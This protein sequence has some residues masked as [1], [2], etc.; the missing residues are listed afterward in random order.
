MLPL[1]SLHRPLN[2]KGH[3]FRIEGFSSLEWP[4]GAS[5]N[6]LQNG[7]HPFLDDM[8]ADFLMV[9]LES[10][11]I[12]FV[13]K[14]AER[15]VTDIMQQPCKSQKFFNIRRGRELAFFDSIKGWIKLLRE[16][17]GDMHGP[18]RVLEASV[19][20]SGKYPSSAL[21][22][23]DTTKSLNP[24]GIDHIPFGFFP[25]YTVGHHDIVINRVGDQ[26]DPLDLF[27]F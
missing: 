5:P 9:G 18:E 8:L 19:F 11:E 27:H 10:G 13:K 21:E 6:S 26:P 25:L 15:A 22:L 12:L 1:F 4:V 3:L 20:C 14:M 24:E 23:E 7:R 17:P 16:D 2:K